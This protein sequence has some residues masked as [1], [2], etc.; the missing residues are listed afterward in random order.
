MLWGTQK[1]FSLARPGLSA[2]GR[3]KTEF[4]PVFMVLIAP[5]L[6]LALLAPRTSA[7][8]PVV[9]VDRTS[10]LGLAMGTDAACWCD[11]DND[12]WT[13]H[14]HRLRSRLEERRGQAFRAAS[15]RC[16]TSCRRRLRQRRLRGPLLVVHDEGLTTTRV[17]NGFTEAPM[18]ELPKCVS[19]GACWGDFN[20]DGFVDLYVGA[21]TRTGT[22]A[23]PTPT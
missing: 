9:F 15:P 21:A 22:P 23:S 16:E 4:L 8:P 5:L 10:Q 17:G 6:A 20:G 18:P 14:P 1:R 2:G 13:E 12:G 19:R 3:S 11:I 7:A